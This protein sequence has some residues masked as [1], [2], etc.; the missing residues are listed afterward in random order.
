MGIV[1]APSSFWATEIVRRCERRVDQLMP[2]HRVSA[3]ARS[4]DA[5]PCSTDRDV[6][7]LGCP[8]DNPHSSRLRGTGAIVGWG[9]ARVADRW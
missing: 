5:G 3:P 4:T 1:A 2:R 8:S 7:R 9:H 6:P